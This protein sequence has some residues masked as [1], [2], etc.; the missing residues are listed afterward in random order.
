MNKSD[1]ID[2]KMIIENLNGIIDMLI[3]SNCELGTPY[4]SIKFGVFD[5]KVDSTGEDSLG[6]ISR[7]LRIAIDELLT[8]G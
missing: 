4:S 2:Y 1:T 3:S 5:V 7:R 8:E 6:D